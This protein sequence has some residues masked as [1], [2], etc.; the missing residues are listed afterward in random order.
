MNDQDDGEIDLREVL[1]VLRRQI[2]LVVLTVVL[3]L[4]VTAVYLVTATPMFTATALIMVDTSQK[5]L[6]SGQDNFSVP[7]SS[8]NARLESE[9]EILRSDTVALATI[10]R[11]GLLTDPEFRPTIGWLDK[12]RTA[13]G[14]Q[15]RPMPTGAALLNSTLRKLEG[16]T[17]V[18]RRGSTYVIGVEVTSTS[19][20]NAARLAN[21]LSETYIALQ[22]QSKV[23]AALGSRDLLQG[24]LEGARMAMVSSDE[25]LSNYI[26]QNIERLAAE[27]GSTDIEA[28]KAQLS[29]SNAALGALSG[30]LD[31]AQ[32]A[33]AGRD[34]ESLS[35]T[36]QDDALQSLTRQYADLRQQLGQVEAGTQ[37]AID[38]QSGLDRLQQQLSTTAASSIDTLRGDVSTQDQTNASI[39]D[40]F[41]AKVL[42]GNLSSTTLAEIFSLQ[43]EADIAQ[44]QYQTLLSRQR[45]LEAQ[46]LVQVADSRI[47]SS[48]LAPQ[49]ASYP[50]KKRV[51]VLALLASAVVGM[52]L[53]FVVEF[54]VG[55]VT[56]AQQL[57]HLL[58]ARVASVI[59][60]VDQTAEQKSVADRVTDAP[61]SIFSESIRRL[62]AAIDQSLAGQDKS[63]GKVIAVV[64]SIP[65][66][67]KS[68]V[69]IALAR[70]YA[71]AGKKTLLLDVDLRKPSLHKYL[72]LT[73][74]KGFIDFLTGPRSI[75]EIETIYERDL[76]S[77]AGVIMGHGRAKVPTDQLLL[78][79]TFETLIGNTRDALDVT[80]ID[81]PP[82]VPV[83]DAR[84]IVPHADLVVLVVRY[85]TTSQSDLRESFAQLQLSVR[86]GTPILTVLTH[87]ETRAHGYKY[88]GYY[89]SYNED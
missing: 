26:D 10:E 25:T 47:V 72:G 69:S 32:N 31:T 81:T 45:D 27:S 16:A 33:L 60:K 48:A 2:R 50:S 68:S 88:L 41:R 73:P 22:V 23:N 38:L 55:G 77:P 37:A 5:N 18:K 70:T 21:I 3:G 17:S 57:A 86:P 79:D 65:A 59:P 9:V 28:L 78:S 82:L 19:A 80:I 84:Y 11:A 49:S 56:S 71:V 42:G 74:D 4:A 52:G 64:S 46:A 12:M 14:L 51:L 15:A 29:A 39:R 44:R 83:V 8:E 58:P 20:E 43:Q 89:A 63:K 7:G 75:S 36:L 61:L 1:G 30:R 87:D 6:L 24:Q 62:R 54:L 76:K 67:G 66:E 40:Q 35:R 34:W 53:A 13:I 85:G